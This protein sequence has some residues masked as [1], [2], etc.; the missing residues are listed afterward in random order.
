MASAA[1][2]RHLA[3]WL[4][5]K[6]EQNRTS[7]IYPTGWMFDVFDGFMMLHAWE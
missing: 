5:G 7:N 1:P 3:G 6:V 4:Q 2:P